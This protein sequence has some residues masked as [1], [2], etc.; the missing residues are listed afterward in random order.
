MFEA[1]LSFFHR[2]DTPPQ[3]L[4]L[5]PRVNPPARTGRGQLPEH[6]H[7]SKCRAKSGNVE[8]CQDSIALIQH[9]P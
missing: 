7:I 6:N 8:T 4:S 5:E 1:V 2:F 3:S 9:P